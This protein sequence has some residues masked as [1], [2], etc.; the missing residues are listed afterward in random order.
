[1][2]CTKFHASVKKLKFHVII[3][4]VYE[5]DTSCD[6]LITHQGVLPQYLNGFIASGVNYELEKARRPNPRKVQLL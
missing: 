3:Y 4:E 5:K 6:G 1:L 2:Q